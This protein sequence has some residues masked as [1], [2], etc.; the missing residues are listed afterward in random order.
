M[1]QVPQSFPILASFA[2]R[3]PFADCEDIHTLAKIEIRD[4]RVQ[5][6]FDLGS[7]NQA[8]NRENCPIVEIF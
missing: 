6:A 2:I 1:Q 7:V 8:G 4:R 5:D 3:M